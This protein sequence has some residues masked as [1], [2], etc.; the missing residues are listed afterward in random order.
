MQY[1]QKITNISLD[2]G[3]EECPHLEEVKVS[4][5]SGN[6]TVQDHETRPGA[7][8]HQDVARVQIPVD[9]VVNEELC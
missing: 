7:V 1:T 4:E 5:T 9:K 3:S 6:A 8:L 2:N